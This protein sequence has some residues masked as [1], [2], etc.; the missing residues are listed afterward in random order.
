MRRRTKGEVIHISKTK[1]S[2]QQSK[3]KQNISTTVHA[4]TKSFVTFC[5]AQNGESAD[6]NSLVF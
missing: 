6:I 5:S 2:L 3:V 4:T 1:S